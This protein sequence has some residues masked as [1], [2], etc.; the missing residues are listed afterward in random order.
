MI[1]ASM[2]FQVINFQRI[3]ILQNN[4]WNHHFVASEEIRKCWYHG[5]F[6]KKDF[7]F[8]DDIN[9]LRS[10]YLELKKRYEEREE[11]HK[12]EKARMRHTIRTQK[13]KIES[14]QEVIADHE[15]KKLLKGKFFLKKVYFCLVMSTIFEFSRL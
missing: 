7:I 3:L 5:I 6:R 2:K 14:L 8:T 10:R 9:E 1:M 11:F 12:K 15:T 4:P 13:T